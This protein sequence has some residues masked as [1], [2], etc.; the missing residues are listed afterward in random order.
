MDPRFFKRVLGVE[1]GSTRIPQMFPKIIEGLQRCGASGQGLRV[2][3]PQ[4]DRPWLTPVP[5]GFPD[6]CPLLWSHHAARVSLWQ[7]PTG[8]CLSGQ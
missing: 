5:R 1:T 6:P 7:R 2:F 4:H 8:L 3:Q